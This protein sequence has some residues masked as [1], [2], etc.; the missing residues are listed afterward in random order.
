M[1]N[2][3]YNEHMDENTVQEIVRK[4]LTFD[5]DACFESVKAQMQGRI[6]SAASARKIMPLEEYISQAEFLACFYFSDN[7]IPYGFYTREF[8]ERKYPELVQRIRKMVEESVI[9]EDLR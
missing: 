8:V 2:N 4:L 1:G 7:H 3:T 5:Q 9:S 6:K